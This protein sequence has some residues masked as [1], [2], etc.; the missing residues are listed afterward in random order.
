ML[1]TYEYTPEVV[2]VVKSA[3][4][5]KLWRGTEAERVSKIQS[6]I[7]ALWAVIPLKGSPAT[8][9]VWPNQET[10]ARVDQDK[11]AIFMRKPSLIS[12]LWAIA[13]ISDVEI[14]TLWANGLFYKSAPK[15]YRDSVTE[16]KILFV[17]LSELDQIEQ[18][19]LPDK[20]PEEVLAD[21]RARRI[22]A[23]N[24]PEAA[25]SEDAV[26]PLD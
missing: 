8:L 22:E 15:M 25:P 9:N 6:M 20:L 12:A 16:G 3:F 7:N 21:A 17:N 26:E 1:R 5:T 13:E 2:A 24:R 4:K 14:P 10:L 23:R 19:I 18:G 11:N